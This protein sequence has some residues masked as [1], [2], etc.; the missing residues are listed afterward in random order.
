MRILPIAAAALA[1]SA[2]L[3]ALAQDSELSDAAATLSDPA[4]QQMAAVTLSAL[5]EAL[6]DMP[7]APLVDAMANIDPDIADAVD[8]AETLGQLAGPDAADMPAM[9]REELP[10]AMTM[11]GG[12]ATGLEAML[13]ALKEMAEQF[14]RSVEDV[15]SSSSR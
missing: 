4:T 6:L 1:V 3:P 10:Q 12:M 11:M 5:L 14:E 9:V 8:D 2:P 13:P 7:T 15:R